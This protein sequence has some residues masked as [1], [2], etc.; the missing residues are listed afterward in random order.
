MLLKGMDTQ[1]LG[2]LTSGER[3]DRIEPDLEAITNRLWQGPFL[4]GTKPTAADASIAAMLG[5]MAS[6]PGGTALS[7]RV[8]QDEVLVKYIARVAAALG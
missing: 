8:Q 4:F 1:G 5:A 6:T 2:R 3:L 7:R